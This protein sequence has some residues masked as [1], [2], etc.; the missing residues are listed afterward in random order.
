MLGAILRGIG[1][2]SPD[3]YNDPSWTLPMLII[4]YLWKNVGYVALIYLAALQAVPTD[5]LEAATLDGAGP[6][7]SF[8]NVLLPL[9][10]PPP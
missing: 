8:R 3:W 1:M 2:G 9:L 5:L 7:G 10:G 6:F 4:V